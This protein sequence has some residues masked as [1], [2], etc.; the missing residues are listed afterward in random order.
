MSEIHPVEI[1]LEQML[2]ARDERAARQ[3]HLLRRFGKPLISFTMNIAGPVKDTPLVRFAFRAA[4]QCIRQ[5]LGVP[6]HS[7]EIFAPTGCEAALVYERSAEELKTFCLALEERGEIGRLY[8]LDVINEQGEKLSRAVSRSCIICGA[9]VSIC[10]RSRAHGLAALQK[11]TE[12]M[13]RAFAAQHLA[14]KAEKALVD[15]VYFTPKPGLVDQNNCG[16]HRDMDLPLFIRSAR[17]LAPHFAAFAA[18]GMEGGT[19]QQ[20]QQAGLAA[21]QAMFAA[22][23]GVNTHKGAIY[24]LALLL[25]AAGIRLCRG[26][27]LLALA[28]QTAA[29]LPQPK[30]TNGSAVREKY[31]IGG[32]REE[33]VEAFPT[34]RGCKAMLEQEGE[35]AALLW[36][37][38]HLEDTTLYYRGGAAGADY[39]RRAAAEILSASPKARIARSMALDE[40]LIRRN[41]SGGGSADLLAL[42]LFLRSIEPLLQ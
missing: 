4:L 13:L 38:A 30:G 6:L 1:S 19:P 31:G 22:T 39:V 23:G 29:A 18:M 11:R 7:E 14:T 2:R 24:S 35:L 27:D 32:V 34:L 16:A 28:A 15:E 33:A 37:M 36:S 26:G 10:S 21:E 40:E 8:D 41:L 20:L 12:E 25:H 3:Q 9:P 17:A 42:A 5:E